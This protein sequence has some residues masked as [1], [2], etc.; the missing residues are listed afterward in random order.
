M[1][2]AHARAVGAVDDAGA[3]R[4]TKISV[5]LFL[6]A[7]SCDRLRTAVN[8]MPV[9]NKRTWCG[10]SHLLG[11][12]SDEGPADDEAGG[13]E[14]EPEP[15]PGAGSGSEPGPQPQPRPQSPFIRRPR[16]L[17]TWSVENLSELE[18]TTTAGMARM[19]L[20]VAIGGQ[21]AGAAVPQDHSGSGSSSRRASALQ[22]LRSTPP[23]P[24][25]QLVLAALK[26]SQ[27]IADHTADAVM[28]ADAAAGPDTFPK[29]GCALAVLEAVV[30]DRRITANST[31]DELCHTILKP[32][33]VPHGW[34]E[35][36]EAVP[37]DWGT[38]YT[39]KYTEHATGAEHLAVPNG[40]CSLADKLH[41]MGH[42][43][44]GEANVFFSH[45]WQFPIVDVVLAMR[46][47]EARERA[48]GNTKPIFYW[49]DVMVVNQ[50]ASE[51]RPPEWWE[52][53]FR[54]AVSDIG[55]TCLM[56]M[57]W[58]EPTVMTRAWCLWEVYCT[59]EAEAC[60]SCRLTLALAPG[61]EDEMVGSVLHHGAECVLR[62]FAQID[63]R[64]AKATKKD[65]RA[66]IMQAI[67]A[68]PGATA[69]NAKVLE[70]A[71]QWVCE[72]LSARIKTQVHAVGE[73]VWSR[74]L[75]LLHLRYAELMEKLRR[76]PEARA[77]CVA[78]L[79]GVAA[80]EVVF[81]TGEFKVLPP[82]NDVGGEPRPCSLPVDDELVLDLKFRLSMTGK[83]PDDGNLKMVRSVAE[84][85]EHK[86]GLTD[87]KAF[88]V[89]SYE[90]K[91]LSEGNAAQQAEA[92][93]R[94]DSMIPRVQESLG[95]EHPLTL[96]VKNN[97]GKLLL[98]CDE[99][100]RAYDML[101]A[102]VDGRK[103]TLGKDHP[104]TL[105]SLTFEA[106]ALHA[107]GDLAVARSQLEGV[108]ESRR[109]QSGDDHAATLDV[110]RRLC[111][112][113]VD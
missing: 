54:R 32:S 59:I 84:V 108:L 64:H 44:I 13:P 101:H 90:L 105:I 113:G 91:I 50:H 5:S 10:S 94:F 43:G 12:E 16:L 23:D 17:A 61:Q 6:G 57:P 86:Y 2:T 69:L 100:G 107:Q 74:E 3:G 38:R 89:R 46:S 30:R 33:T 78:A 98:D 85:Y 81:P 102:A 24:S 14:P 52:T 67:E 71:R 9:R 75:G 55:H 95:Q 28:A 41:R 20:A 99:P 29:L 7:R 37:E 76:L 112:W 8:Q 60:G 26:K 111:E 110:Q 73:R 15:E 36:V 56:M 96:K 58:D 48:A 93:T 66:K 47:F 19:G 39:A 31:T 87:A 18:R 53:A 63:C 1:V 103:K 49:F 70:R 35:H 21:T 62:S 4:T 106:V 72:T 97:F 65:D 80:L 104:D 25:D 68:G 11:S 42:C 79:R 82:A 27:G 77:I 34:E 109:A 22:A 51:S 40:T 45:A 88:R 83:M 92:R